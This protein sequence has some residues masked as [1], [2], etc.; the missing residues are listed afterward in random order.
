M[1]DDCHRVEAKDFWRACVQIRQKMEAKAGEPVYK[2]DR[3]VKLNLKESHV[4]IATEWRLK[5]SGEPV[6]KLDRRVELKDFWRACVQIRQKVKLN[7]IVKNH[8]C[9]N[10]TEWRLKISGEPVYKLDRRITCVT[11][12]NQVEAKDFWRACVQI[13]QK[14]KLN[15]M[16]RMEAKDFWRACVQIRQKN[17]M[18]DD[19]FWM[20]HRVEAKD[21][22]R[23]CVQ[24]R[25]KVKLNLLSRITC[26]TIATEWRLKISGEPVYKLDRRVEAKDFW[27]ACVQI[28]QKVKLNLL[29]RITCVT[30][31]RLKI[32]GEPQI[33]QKVKLNLLKNHMP[34]SRLKISGEP[35]YKG[36]VEF[37]VI[38]QKN[39]MC[40]DCHR[41]EA[42]DFWRACVQIRQKVKLNLMS[43]SRITCVTIATE[44]KAKDFWRACVQI[45]Q[46]VKLNL[47]SRI[48]CVT[49]ATEWR[50]K[51][52][53][54]PVYKLDRRVEAKDFWR[55]CV[56][57]RQKV[58]LNLLSRIT[59]VTIATEW[60]LQEEGKVEFNVKNHMCDDCHR[61]E[62][63]DFWRACVQIRQKVKLNLMSRITCDDCHRVEAKDFWRACVQIRQKVKLNLLSRITCVTIAT[64]WRLKISGEPVYKLDRRITCEDCH[65]VE[66]KDFWRAC[67]QIR[68]KVKL[69]LMSRTTCV[70]IA[71]EW[72]LKISGEPVY[73]LDRRVEA[74]DFWRACVQIRQKVKL[75]LMSRILCHR[76]EAKDFWRA[77][78]QIRQKVLD[79]HRVEAKDFC[80]QI[81]QKNHMCDDCHRVEAKDFW[82]ACVQIRQKVKL[83]LMSR[84]TCVTP[85]SV[86]AKDFWRACVQIRQKVKLNL[87]VKL[88]EGHM[89]R[90]I[91]ATEWRLKIS[92]EPVYK[93]DRRVEAKDF[94][95]ACVQIR[96]KVKLNLMSRITCVTIA[97]EWRLK[98]SGEPVYK[99][100]R[101][102]EAKDF[103]RACVQIRQKVKLNL[104][105]RI[106]RSGKDFWRALYKLDRRFEFN[107]KNHMCDDCHRVE[108]K[109]FWRA[110][111][112]IRQ[113][114]KHKKT[115]YYLEQ[116][117]L[118]HKAHVNTVNIKPCH[119]GLDFFYIQQQDARKLNSDSSE[120]ISHDI[121]NNTFNYKHTF[122]G[123]HTICK[124]NIVC[125]PPKLAQ[126]L[127]N[128]N[129]L[130]LC[131]KV[132][133]TIH[134][135][136]PTSLQ[137]A[138]VKGPQYW[139]YPF[140]NVCEP[141]QLVE[142]MVIDV[143]IVADKDKP[144][145]SPVSHK[146]GIESY[147]PWQIKT[148]Q[149]TPVSH[150]HV[151]ANVCVNQVTS[152]GLS[153]QQYFC[154]THLG[155]L[156]HP[157]DSVLGFN[158][159]NCNLNHAEFDK[160]KADKIPDV[161]LHLHDD[162]HADTSSNER[163]Y[164]DFLEDLEEDEA[165]RKNV[166]IY[167]DADKL[168]VDADDT[169]DEECPQISLQEM[170]DDLHISTDATGDD[171]ADMM[172]D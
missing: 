59:C 21:F 85:Q 58:K 128:I 35:V 151:L 171:G 136:D 157:G 152:T 39:H 32:S 81:R 64:E 43:L 119:E 148:N 50:L 40:D 137:V 153:D 23:A 158:F 77:C 30:E 55:A 166:D 101:R 79:C 150:K 66:A 65:R 124:D 169:D 116:I 92:G 42:K 110:C 112:Q 154:R 120:L 3:S 102:V 109:D 127:G 96:Q 160:M 126:H 141:K 132:T 44:W 63:K 61:V 20:C 53:G 146:V 89:S 103:W 78:V 129:P 139:R 57:I 51:I 70:T 24:I 11:A 164:T 165:F 106:R 98:I 130:S 49:I 155:H 156:L 90:I 16:S 17:H 48:T 114:T 144:N 93:L 33:R 91:C 149:K 22:W 86:E 113:K 31:W 27:R 170:L 143:E 28:R 162:L 83:N 163:D 147:F 172:M 46:K 142:F 71:T 13:R 60:R 15:L 161:M 134:V 140:L 26:V 100:D 88:E 34:Q 9:D 18:C 115:F 72:R 82:R 2:L 37:V 135:I 45:R 168:A 1:C 62:A 99:L 74:K 19:D 138:E 12:K 52:S 41:V 69:N 94:W 105:S 56:Q 67:V 145:K 68:Q 47:L 36:K 111:V 84:I 108:A 29:S 159:T 121:H 76:V 133:N 167:K 104:M 38:R 118:K 25:Q 4:G 117:I 80:V 122:C 5:I 14:V 123:D 87:D 73:K 54:E 125:L 131:Y 97:T 95:R 75:N 107:V 10:A 6:Y 8:M 7:L